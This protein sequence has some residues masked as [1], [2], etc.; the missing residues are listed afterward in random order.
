MMLGAVLLAAAALRGAAA[1]PMSRAHAYAADKINVHL[2]AHTHDD[3]GW[4]KTVDQYYY[5]SNNSIYHAGM[6][7]WPCALL[8]CR[9]SQALLPPCCR[10]AV[11]PRLRP[12]RSG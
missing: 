10:R 5:G 9:N 12:G 3:P 2:F 4:L 8:S 1:A 6:Y 11:H 7:E